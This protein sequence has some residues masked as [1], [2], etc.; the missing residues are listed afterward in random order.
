VNWF[1]NLWDARRKIAVWQ[2]EF[3][4]STDHDP[5]KR[6]SYH[7]HDKIWSFSNQHQ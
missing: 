2:K 3:N 4:E 1:E 5:Q 6:P 7:Q